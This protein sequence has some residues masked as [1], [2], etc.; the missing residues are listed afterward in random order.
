[1]IAGAKGNEL[2]PSC[3]RVA[4]TAKMGIDATKPLG[5]SERFEKVRIPGIENINPFDSP[6]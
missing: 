1:M 6:V 5:R 4:L 3:P 2:D